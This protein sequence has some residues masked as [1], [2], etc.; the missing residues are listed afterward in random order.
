MTQE[1]HSSL[2]RRR[3]RRN[4]RHIATVFAS[5]GF[6]RRRS[7]RNTRAPSSSPWRHRRRLA[8]LSSSLQPPQHPL[9]HRRLHL[10]P[11]P[12]P[13]RGRRVPGSACSGRA[14]GPRLFC[15]TTMQLRLD[16][17][18][19]TTRSRFDFDSTATRL[20]LEDFESTLIPFDSTSTR[21]RL[22]V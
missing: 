1:E 17:D 20:H 10:A 7:P 19:T 4:T 21:P 6:R 12:A 22:R 14:S 8:R 16:F 15:S 11:S 18:S 3:S 5:C 13:T 2:V 9:C